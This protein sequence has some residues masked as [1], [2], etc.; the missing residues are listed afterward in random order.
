M[1]MMPLG[2]TGSASKH[3]LAA[4]L[5][6]LLETMRGAAPAAVKLSKEE[7]QARLARCTLDA[8]RQTAS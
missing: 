3:H 4:T 2:E 7:W 6:E 5:A 1:C 8:A